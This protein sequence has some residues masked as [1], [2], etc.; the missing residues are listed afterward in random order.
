ARLPGADGRSRPELPSRSRAGAD[1]EPR[2]ADQPRAR[3]PH[4]ARDG[5]LACAAMSLFDEIR[6]GCR[7]VAAQASH[8]RI[9]HGRLAD[10]AGTLNLAESRA[11]ALDPAYHYLG[12]G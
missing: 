2:R 5:D 7:A 9:D 1:G 12:Q 10:Y 6:D 8:V 11:P 4:R 3:G